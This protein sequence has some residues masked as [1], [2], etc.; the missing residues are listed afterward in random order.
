MKSSDAPGVAQGSR[1][2]FHY[3]LVTQAAPERI[4][5]VWTDVEGWNRWDRGLK[6]ATIRE[7]FS[8]GASGV[9][10]PL[11]GPKAKFVVT[12]V[13]EGR[14]YTFETNLP[15]GKL[16][17]QRSIISI[18]EDTTTFRHDVGFRGALGWFWALSYG[19]GFMKALPPTMHELARIAE[20]KE[21]VE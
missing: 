2:R 14:S 7:K 20:T 17:V 3:T 1:S 5:E 6:A 11:S 8:E 4:W 9:I 21:E 19:S 15:L 13:A 12:D 18:E 10:T 16:V